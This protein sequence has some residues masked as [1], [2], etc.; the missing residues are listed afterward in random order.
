[1]ADRTNEERL[2]E[3]ASSDP[4]A[5]AICAQMGEP[6]WADV[7]AIAAELLAARETIRSKDR[8]LPSLIAEGVALERERAQKAEA[9]RDAARARIAKLEQEPPMAMVDF[10]VGVNWKAIYEE[11]QSVCA[12][13][14]GIATALATAVGAEECPPVTAGNLHA[15]VDECLARIARLAH[16]RYQQTE[17]I[18]DAGSLPSHLSIAEDFETVLDDVRR[19]N[20]Q[21]RAE[22][23]RL[24]AELR[25]VATIA[26]EGGLAELGEGPPLTAIRRRTLCWWD[27]TGSRADAYARVRAAMKHKETDQ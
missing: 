13:L 16:R 6:S 3:I 21:L 17:R 11:R 19:E 1:M 23:E 5:L 25:A 15:I 9:E 12:A 4:L 14:Q 18:V 2:R 10:G 24:R 27:R 20:E 8:L 26:H 7:R 22:V